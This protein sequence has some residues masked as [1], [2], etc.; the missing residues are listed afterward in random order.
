MHQAANL[1]VI[2]CEVLSVIKPL[3]FIL[4][5]NS[6]NQI[7]SITSS[8]TSGW[9]LRTISYFFVDI[10]ASESNVTFHLEGNDLPISN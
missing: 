2:S 8:S 3:E 1:F 6:S 10:S 9:N 5:S 7:L 4:K